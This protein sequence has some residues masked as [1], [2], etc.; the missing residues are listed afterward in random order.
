MVTTVTAVHL[1]T[2]SAH[3]ITLPPPDSRGVV[4]HTGRAAAPTRTNRVVKLAVQ[5]NFVA[6]SGH[7]N[8]FTLYL[9]RVRLD[10]IEPT[11]D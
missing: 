6:R 3:L 5:R 4:R 11:H 9:M 2:R 10:C 7:V 1:L 8:C